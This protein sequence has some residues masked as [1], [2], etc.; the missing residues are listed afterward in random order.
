MKLILVIRAPPEREGGP[1]VIALTAGDRRATVTDDGER[2]ETLRRRARHVKGIGGN[3]GASA[4]AAVTSP[5]RMRSCSSRA[6]GT[7]STNV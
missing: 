5:A 4:R 2:R 3:T 1:R 7:G 6:E